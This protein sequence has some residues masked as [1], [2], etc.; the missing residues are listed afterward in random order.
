MGI[1]WRPW[2]NRTI[3][4]IGNNDI[5]GTIKH[6]QKL[7]EEFCPGYPFEYEFVDESFG[8]QYHAEIRLSRILMFFALIAVFLAGLG[9]FGMSAFMAATRRKEIGI[10]K[11]T[12][13]SV[14][15]IIFLFS[16]TYT[17]WILIAFAIAAPTAWFLL[18]KWLSQYPYQTNISWWVFVLAFLI[19][20]II[21][22]S[23]IGYQ[24]I[25]SARMNPADSLRYE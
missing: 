16:G 19:S 25:K 18:K 20:V 8:K 5:P 10:R 9:L 7:Y 14:S 4:N 23:T 17:K 13:A 12:G 3:V 24:I 11:A 6:L 21:A 22:L 1:Q 2:P 15:E